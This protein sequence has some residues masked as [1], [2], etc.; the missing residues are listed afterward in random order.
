MEYL[1]VRLVIIT[2]VHI[3]ILEK[4]YHT[5]YSISCSLNWLHSN[6]YAVN[7]LCLHSHRECFQV[8]DLYVPFLE[9]KRQKIAISHP[10]VNMT[11]QLPENKRKCIFYISWTKTMRRPSCNSSYKYKIKMNNKTPWPTMSMLTVS[12]CKVQ[13]QFSASVH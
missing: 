13:F 7:S 4:N 9:R 3:I 5:Y 6:M 10:T 1:I 8:S 2:K 12:C 11:C